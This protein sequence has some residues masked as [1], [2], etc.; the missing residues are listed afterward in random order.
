MQA[1][2]A[3]KWNVPP[4]PPLKYHGGISKTKEVIE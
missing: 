2:K 4:H 1:E 3:C